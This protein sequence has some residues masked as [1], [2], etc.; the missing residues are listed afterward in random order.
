MQEL[1]DLVADVEAHAEL[2]PGDEERFTGYA[3]MSLPFSSG[4]VLG[5]RRFPVTSVGPGYTSVWLRNPVGAWTIYTTVPADVSCPRYFGSA[6]ESTSIHDIGITWLDDRSFTVMIADEVGLAWTVRLAA[7]RMTR[8]MSGVAHS[9]PQ[10]FW[11]NA[12]FLTMMGAVAGPALRA[13]RIGMT[14]RTPNTQLFKASPRRM[15][16]VESSTATL[17][18]QDL[19]A[20][21]ALPDQE[22]LG[23]FW[24]PQRGIFMI[25]GAAFDAL[26]PDAAIV[27]TAAG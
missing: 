7:T 11:R 10:A 3:L 13:G 18:G 19:G 22:R 5:L 21:A 20:V 25:G 16:V 4:H 8:M 1:R 27:T 26:A 9:L 24:M 23:D 6:L 12:P 15:W 2:A 17:G 14:G